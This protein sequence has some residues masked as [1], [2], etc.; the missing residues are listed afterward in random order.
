[1]YHGKSM[2]VKK[3]VNG[4]ITDEKQVNQSC[5][6]AIKNKSVFYLFFFSF[7]VYHVYSISFSIYGLT[8]CLPVFPLQSY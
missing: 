2:K 5:N 7:K 4:S 8:A 1:M 6:Q 3:R